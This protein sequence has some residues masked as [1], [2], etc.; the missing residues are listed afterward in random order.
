MTTKWSKITLHSVFLR[1]NFVLWMDS[2]MPEQHCVQHRVACLWLTEEVKV[3]CVSLDWIVQYN[4]KK[5][6]TRRTFAETRASSPQLWKDCWKPLK[7]CT[8][9]KSV[10]LFEAVPRRVT[11]T[12]KIKKGWKSAS[13]RLKTLFGFLAHRDEIQLHSF[14][15]PHEISVLTVCLL[16]KRQQPAS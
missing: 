11:N 7:N 14:I 3:H 2:R 4:S 10:L 5:S 6:T 9:K 13:T 15:K 8:L 1:Q 12:A 16:E